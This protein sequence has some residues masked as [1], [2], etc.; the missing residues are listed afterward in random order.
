MIGK[1]IYKSL[2]NICVYE[3]RKYRWVLF[4]KRFIQTL[5]KK[6]QPSKPMLPY[7]KTFLIFTDFFPGQICLLGLGGGSILHTLAKNK[8]HASMTIVEKYAEMIHIAKTYFDLPQPFNYQILCLPAEEFV[9]ESTQSYDHLLIDLGDKNGYPKEC[10]T[11][12]FFEHCYRILKSKGL[13]AL[14]ITHHAQMNDFK[15]IL[16]DIFH[17]AP[18]AFSAK[19]NWILFIGKG[20]SKDELMQKLID[21]HLL[22]KWVWSHQ[23]GEISLIN[24]P[25]EKFLT[26]IKSIFWLKPKNALIKKLQ[27]Q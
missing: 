16:Q 1:R 8:Q 20:I 22:K 19:G 10:Q 11:P 7:I 27:R 25:F 13:L 2:D 9:T 24:S 18:V 21:E 5:I 17:Q 3:N 6:R 15:A 14:N 26:K 12:F 23:Y 4:D